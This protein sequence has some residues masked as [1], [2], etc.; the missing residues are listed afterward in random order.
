[1]YCILVTGIPAAGKSTMAAFLAD[2]L[3]LP[4]LS[5]DSIKEI[6]FDDLGFRSREEKVRLGVAGMHVMYYA[7]EQ[8]MKA[9]QPFILENNFENTSRD[10]LVEILRRHGYRAITVVLTGDYKVIYRRFCKRDTDPLRHRGHVVN[11]CYPEMDP[12]ARAKTISFED[13]ADGIARRGMDSFAV[14]GPRIVVDTTDFGKVDYEAVRRQITDLL[15][16]R[17]DD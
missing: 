13:F 10:G 5:K 4:V 8:L 2:A 15:E 12:H 6:L 11:D 9:R 1:M 3:G 14:D 16:T 7:A 17:N